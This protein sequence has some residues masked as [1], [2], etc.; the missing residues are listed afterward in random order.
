M[1]TGSIQNQQYEQIIRNNGLR[2]AAKAPEPPP[3]T[4]DET[5][6]IKK[7]FTPV[8]PG[9]IYN[10]QGNVNQQSVSSLGRHIDTKV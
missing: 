1:I 6:M 4:N 8:K 9:K 3:L 10:V 2:K 7:K 5:S